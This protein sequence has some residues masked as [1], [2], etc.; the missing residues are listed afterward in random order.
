MTGP[1]RLG[2]A[3]LMALVLALGVAGSAAGAP[4]GQISD[5]PTPTMNSQPEG[6]V[7]GPDGNLWF[8]EFSGNKI[9]AVNPSTHGIAEFSV[10]T[11]MSQP[12]GVALG[13]DGNIWFTEWG[14]NK[15][16]EIDPTTH[17]FNQFPIP[18]PNSGP[19]AIVEG[20]D[21]NMWFTEQFG[22]KIGEISPV[23][24]GFTEFPV[25]TATSQ[26]FGIAAGPDGNVWFTEKA[27]SKI[28]VIN[29]STHTIT[30]VPTPT[31]NALPNA[32]AAGPDGN[33]WFTE[34]NTGVKGIGVVKPGPPPVITEIQTPT[35]N[36]QP[37]VITPGPD[38]NM[39]F[40]E[41]ANPGRVAFINTVS[42]T[43][44]MEFLTPTP[45]SA[46]VGIATGSDGNLWFTEFGTGRVGVVGA[47]ATAPV[48]A[49]AT[50]TGVPQPGG[51]LTCQPATFVSYAG[52]QPSLSAFG[53]DGF[54]WLSN[55]TQIPGATSQTHT[56]TS[57]DVGHQISCRETVT[58]RLVGPTVSANSAPVTVAPS[59]GA[60]LMTTSVSGSTAS[61]AIACQGLP[62]QTCSGP[63]TLTSRVTTQGSKTIA[64][65]ARSKRKHKR[66]KKV[67]R[68]VTVA[69]GSYSV[70]A[71]HSTT[72]TLKLNRAGQKLL[73][74]FYRLP[75]RVAIGGTTPITTTVT[76]SYGRLHIS[77]GFTWVITNTF[78]FATK[79][80]LPGL[81][82][83]ART[84]VICHGGGCPFSTRRFSTPRH[85]TLDLA[86]AFEH[87]HLAP[88]ATIE[89][90]ISA[91]TAVTEVVIFTINAG[92]QPTEAFRC[93]PPGAHRPTAC[94]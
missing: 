10:P 37:V 80:T 74:Q 77:P 33:L 44:G 8:A 81:P 34:M 25:T 50:V 53:F 93:M 30:E 32:I 86:P 38:G 13:P 22:N 46:P 1:G 57:A 11:G 91:R 73:N 65:A 61:L 23:T 18:T 16:G 39:W 63:I 55:G 72:I 87:R 31:A 88:H 89:L 92:K 35:P 76:F 17:V 58:Y 40:T 71:G 3:L 5:F 41:G 49:A 85:G 43:P 7:A 20:A 9:A 94:A 4:L 26:P 75:A 29:L 62:T 48:V 69:T 47:G 68:T 45:N 36:A 2:S 64:V 60:S 59:L 82:R 70:A 21:G 67:T 24:H 19:V 12:L 42:Q 83:Q 6:I 84:T 54:R 15:I 51:T 14:A 66:P 79:L 78:T 90:R 56:L 27:A 28:G 52:Q